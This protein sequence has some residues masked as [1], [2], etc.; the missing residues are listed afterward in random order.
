MT[1]PAPEPGTPVVS[2][3]PVAEV[4][5]T[6]VPTPTPS[7]PTFEETFGTRAV[8]LTFNP[9]QDPIVFQLKEKFAEIIDILNGHRAFIASPETKR[10]CSV[11]IT[12]AQGAQ[13]WAV[14]AI[15]W[16]D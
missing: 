11:A 8:G 3:T 1:Q 5:P 4:A 13:M 12:E 2:Q 6:P 9:S 7:L 14:K 16:N 15:T 10:L